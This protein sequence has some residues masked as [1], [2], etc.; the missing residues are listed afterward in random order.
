MR[1]RNRRIVGARRHAT[2]VVIMFC[3]RELATGFCVEDK[4]EYLAF[5]QIQ[6]REHLAGAATATDDHALAASFLIAAGCNLIGLL[7]GFLL[8]AAGMAGAPLGGT[9]AYIAIAGRLHCHGMSKAPP[10]QSDRREWTH[11]DD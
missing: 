9:A 1:G 8:A 3:G 11:G 4:R 10:E 2:M 7:I 5:G 6:E